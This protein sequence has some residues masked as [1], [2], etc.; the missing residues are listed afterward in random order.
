M[1]DASQA[2]LAGLNE[3]QRQA[4]EHAGSPLLI[5]AGAGSGKT[6]V[7]THRIAHLLSARGVHPGEIL[8]ITFT[9]KA[10]AEMRERVDALVGPRSR[11]MWVSTFHSACL[12]ILRR[13]AH[14]LGWK[15]NFTIYD[16]D[17]ARRLLTQIVK[18][19]GLD[20]KK[21]SPRWFAAEISRFKNELIGPEQAADAADD[22]KSRL[23]ADVYSQYTERLRLAA[24]VD[25][26]DIIGTTGH[27]LRTF[28]EVAESYR[29]RFR[30]VMV[31]EYQDTNHAQYVLIRELV[32]TG[33]NAAELCV[34][35]DADQSIYAFR[36]ATIRNIVEFERDYPDAKTIL[37]EQNYRS[38]Q[39]IL[40]AANNVIR[41]NSERGREKK[42]W[43]DVGD[44]PRILG[45]TG[46]N[47][48]DE[49]AWVANRVDA[50]VDES[51][52]SFGDVAIFYRTNAQSRAFEEVFVRRGIP[53][54]VVGGVRFY[55]R[56]EVR[57]MLAYLKLTVNGDDTVSAMRVVNV[58]KRG[59][60]DR[61]VAEIE[62]LA[63]RERISFAAALHRAD[64]APGVSSRA[65]GGIKQFCE[66]IDAATELALTAPPEEVLD[67]LIADTGYLEGLEQS[68]DPRDEGR[69]EN[70]QELVAVSHEFTEQVVRG[71]VDAADDDEPDAAADVASFL[72]HVA[73]VSDAD[74]IPDPESEEGGQVTLMTLHTAKGLEF[75]TVFLTGM[76]DG[77]FPHERSMSKPTEL[78]EERRLAYVG[79]TRA[80]KHLHLTRAG[81]RNIFGQPEF[82]AASR[83]LS[84]IPSG[85]IEWSE[86]APPPSRVV[87]TGKTPSFGQP[88]TMRNPADVPSLEVGDRITHDK[89]GLG[90]VVELKGSGPRAQARIDF[91]DGEPKWVILRLAPVSKL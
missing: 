21:N 42:L 39:T 69:V 79:L 68:T 2:L 57:D 55:E 73:L 12:R 24:A 83:F 5:V 75:D 30:H 37:L 74:S 56:K 46:D 8:A 22:A 31:D 16:T 20:S 61:A 87:K 15:S 58:P 38:T 43:S 48:H 86:S 60:G 11:A 35:G 54:K 63:A 13:E 59:V 71:E 64:E 47:E 9:N 76:D 10:A 34:V 28:P 49:A 85:L 3:P 45:H 84:E 4:A 23:I 52:T 81:T 77:L 41:N 70:L 14:R 65:R 66:I 80:R 29:L 44:G 36:G 88:I 1:N 89:W 7:L 19:L 62:A 18:E 67:K 53:Y 27:L 72:E 32:G 26:D 25:F 17:D 82:Y 6:R 90:R 40:D 91:G 33:D 78:E 51:Q 50:L